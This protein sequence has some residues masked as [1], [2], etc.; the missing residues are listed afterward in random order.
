MTIGGKYS[1]SLSKI[2]KLQSSLDEA[3]CILSTP[4]SIDSAH[5]LDV[6]AVVLL[7]ADRGL[8]SPDYQASWKTFLLLYQMVRQYQS[9]P[10]LIQ[11]Y[12]PDHLAIVHACNQNIQAMKTLELQRREQFQYPP[13]AQ[14]CVLHYKNEIEF[15]TVSTTTKLYQEL[16]YLKQAYEYTNLEIRSTPPS[17]FKKFGKYRYTIVMKGP[18]LR[19]FMD[20]AYSKLKMRS[21]GFKVDWEPQA[22]I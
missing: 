12:K 7:D 1:N 3:Q 14:M 10:V 21:R 18:G 6:D 20:I 15:R 2:K 16:E 4:M 17:I 9:L 11:S 5:G 19:E 13:F 8:F 22:L